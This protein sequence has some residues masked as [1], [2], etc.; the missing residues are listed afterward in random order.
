MCVGGG[1]RIHRKFYP[2]PLMKRGN[3][4]IYPVIVA[5]KWMMVKKTKEDIQIF[6]RPERL[7]P[8]KS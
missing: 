5:D 3:N 8:K 4:E 2:H 1:G 6:V 7:L